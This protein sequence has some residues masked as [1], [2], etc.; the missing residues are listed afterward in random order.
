MRVGVQFSGTV[1]ANRTVRYF[2]HSWN[3]AL[4][5]LWTAVPT[6]PHRGARQIKWEVQIE[7]A[8]N[9]K[10]TYWIIITN[11]TSRNVNVEGRYAIL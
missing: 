11:L 7:R 3:P 6:T 4:H 10:V 8:A 1:R 5:V 2:T 9:N